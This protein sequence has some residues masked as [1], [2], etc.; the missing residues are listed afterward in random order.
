MRRI[1]NGEL[2]PTSTIFII[3]VRT[4]LFEGNCPKV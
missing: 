3:V 4:L 1:E 2:Q